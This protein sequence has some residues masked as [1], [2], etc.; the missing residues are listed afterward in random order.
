MRLSKLSRWQKSARVTRFM[1]RMGIKNRKNLW[2]VRA[3]TVAG[4][5]IGLTAIGVTAAAM[6]RTDTAPA[7]QTA[8]VPA[9]RELTYAS[10]SA[11]LNPSA[12][13][14][15]AARASAPKAVAAT[16]PIVTLTGCLERD[17]ESFR[18]KDTDG[19]DAPKSRSWKTGFLTKRK[20]AIEVADPANR[21]QSH[22]GERVSVTGVLVDRE[23]QVQSLK[24][25]AST[26][27]GSSQS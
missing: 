10:T 17:D 25:V 18:L 23:M 24:R 15:A 8:R 21:L 5:F 14:P 2:K 12:A 19:A 13:A 4:I 1:R 16:A 27:D 11:A 26:C 6:R 9:A 22:I 20:A 7:A 3:A